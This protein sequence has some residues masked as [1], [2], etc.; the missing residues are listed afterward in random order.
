MA[1]ENFARSVATASGLA[2][3]A[4]LAATMPGAVGDAQNA[5]PAGAPPTTFAAWKSITP[6][7]RHYIENPGGTVPLIVTG[8]P[9]F[10]AGQYEVF[11]AISEPDGRQIS[12]WT[13]NG[14]VTLYS[15]DK[16]KA[17]LQENGGVSLARNAPELLPYSSPAPGH[18]MIY[19]RNGDVTRWRSICVL[20]AGAGMTVR[21]QCFRGSANVTYVPAASGSCAAIPG[22][23]SWFVNGDVTFLAG[24]TLSQGP[25]TGRWTCDTA[26]RRVIIVWSHGYTDDLVLSPDGRRLSGRND[27]QGSVA[28]QKR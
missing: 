24:G 6:D 18:A 16:W 21:N 15:G 11:T 2:V 9:W 14:L 8:A 5:P 13:S 3:A 7:Q 28:G 22:L 23:W 27:R 4:V 12:T 17:T 20:P 1:F 19:A 10:R 25:R 26:S